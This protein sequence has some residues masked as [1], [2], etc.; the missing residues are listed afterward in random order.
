MFVLGKNHVEQEQLNYVSEL[1]SLLGKT[2]NFFKKLDMK[3]VQEIV[4]KG[5]GELMK[6]NFVIES[7]DF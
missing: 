4:D 7:S 5:K 3:I 2:N 6:K 1:S